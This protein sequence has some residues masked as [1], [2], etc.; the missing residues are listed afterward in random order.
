MFAIHPSTLPFLLLV[1][2]RES[3]GDLEVIPRDFLTGRQMYSVVQW[4][5]FSFFL[6]A[7]P[8]KMVLPKKG[9]FFP[10]S[11]T[12]ECMISSA[13]FRWD[14]KRNQETSSTWGPDV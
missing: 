13:S 10:G 5:P 11:R 8:Q 4:H 6:L 9:S 12:T 7:A 2:D 3:I 14:Y 1:L